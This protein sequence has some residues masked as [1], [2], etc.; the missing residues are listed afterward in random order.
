MTNPWKLPALAALLLLGAC[1]SFRF[2]PTQ[3]WL[4]EGGRICAQNREPVFWDRAAPRS[5]VEASNI[6][7]DGLKG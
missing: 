6:A 3:N 2:E 4:A 1:S 5:C 7:S